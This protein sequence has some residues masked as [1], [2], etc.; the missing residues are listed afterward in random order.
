MTPIDITKFEQLKAS[1]DLPSP[2]GVALAIMQL[3]ARDDVSN[4]DL[5]RIIK[6]DP[7]FV[8]RL[9]KAA[10]GV[11]ALGYGKRPVVS[12]QDA[13]MVLGI[14][15]VRT[16]ALSFSLLSQYNSGAC[17]GFD[18]GNYW[19]ESLACALALQAVTAA[20]RVAP[21]EEAF[22]V[23][24]LA[25]IGELALATL[26]PAAYAEM[27][28]RHRRDP[29]LALVDLERTA[30]AMDHRELSASML[31]DWGV[32]KVFSEAVFYHESADD[33]RFAEGSR[34]HL[35]AQSLALARVIAQ[36]CV[37]DDPARGSLIGRSLLLG[38]RL[39]IDE[40]ALAQ[41]CDR[42]AAEWNE[43][44]AILDVATRQVAPFDR[45]VHTM[46]DEQPAS[47]LR[48]GSPEPQAMR[49]LIVDDDPALRAVL[50]AGLNRLGNEVFEAADGRA[51]LEIALEMRPHMMIVDWVMPEMDG[52]ALTRALR[53]TKLGHAIFIMVLTG[54]EDDQRLIEAFEAG[55]DDYMA[56]PLKPRVLAARL[57]A[58]QRVI[59]LQQEIERDREDIRRFAAEL[60]VTNRRLQEVAL[61]DVLTGL[62]N[63]RFAMERIHQEWSL[64]ARAN[65]AL[66]CLI[67]DIDEFKRVNDTYGHDVGDSVLRH[68]A[69]LLKDGLRTHDVISRTGGD[70][71]L[72]ICPDTGLPAALICAER[73]RRAVEAAP[74]SSGMLQ[75][76]G[77]VSI[78]VATREPTMVDTDALIKRADQGAYVA[79]QQ[80]RNRVATVQKQNP[81]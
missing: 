73:L 25:R 33:G 53:Q 48:L 75:L 32:P 49:V 16:L 18:Y 63:R 34:T 79:K 42:V 45:I 28:A 17:S 60:A 26:Y 6:T 12:V 24:L 80:G 59:K 52:I 1:G 10:N 38:S 39:S 55:V 22:S 13:V 71:F 20:T 54:F 51:A 35:M 4:A 65:R 74:I 19:S 40:P 62:P 36:N 66:S 67:V 50:R 64:A 29:D 46:P 81:S 78:G 69:K 72:A 2:K 9:V 27:L 43:W 11:N 7:A 76:R 41:L 31:A 56:K 77:T 30:F 8:G 57:R 3:M 23:G 44:G 37:A 61:T 5:A 70:E 14:P 21:A 58:G 15:A 68:I 47:P